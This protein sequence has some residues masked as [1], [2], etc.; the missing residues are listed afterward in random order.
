MANNPGGNKYTG[1]VRSDTGAPLEGVEVKLRY[2]NSSGQSVLKTAKTGKDGVWNATIENGIDL[3]TVTITYVK[4]G[5]SSITIKNP[6]VSDT[7]QFPPPSINPLSG[8]RFNLK[9]AYDSGKYLVSS[10][11]SYDQSLL[12]YNLAG[13]LQ[14]IDNYKSTQKAVIKIDASESQIGNYDREPSA[15]NGTANPNFGAS[16]GQ[17]VLSGY[18]A[19][20]LETYIK[21]YFKDNGQPAPNIQKNPFVSGPPAPSPFPERDTPAYKKVLEDYKEYQ[22]VNIT[23]TFTGPPCIDIPF[24]GSQAGT[25]D[26]IKPAGATK[27]TLDALEFPDRFGFSSTGPNGVTYTD[28]FYQNSKTVGSFISWGFIIYLRIGPRPFPPVPQGSRFPILLPIFFR[29]TGKIETGSYDLRKSLTDDWFLQ[30]DGTINPDKQ[31]IIGTQ[32]IQWN[33]NYASANNIRFDAPF[34]DYK[35]HIDFC[36]NY[37]PRAEGSQNLMYG[38]KITKTDLVY[39]LDGVLDNGPFSISYISGNVAGKSFWKYRLCP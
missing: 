26:F 9:G 6:K 25:V 2:T 34:T 20:N 16:L 5:S 30:S 21:Q 31:G 29:D 4:S 36:F 10:L 14:F 18:R 23:A 39:N 7:F 8:G 12:D 1:V 37:A 24:T 27:I 32:I 35:S 11:S 15:S 38:Y 17:K 19:T 33:L 22:F 28:T 3:S 13:A